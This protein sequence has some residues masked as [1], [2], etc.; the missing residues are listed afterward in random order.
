MRNGILSVVFVG[1]MC[2]TMMPATASGT[3]LYYDGARNNPADSKIYSFDTVTMSNQLVMDL[4]GVFVLDLAAS[5]EPDIIYGADFTANA[6]LAI[7]VRSKV[8]QIR[9]SFGSVQIYSLAYDRENRIL[10]GSSYTDLYIIDTATGAVTQHIGSFGLPTP[11]TMPGLTY[12]PTDGKLYGVGRGPVPNPL[13]LYDIDKNTGLAT[14]IGTN[15][16]DN[17]IADI[18]V[19]VNPSDGVMYGV[20][21]VGGAFGALYTI[22][23]ILG[24]ATFFPGGTLISPGVGY[25]LVGLAAPFVQT[26]VPAMTSPGMAIFGVLILAAAVIMVS[27]RKRNAA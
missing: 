15:L 27:R 8:A 22:D 14:Q 21:G 3:L 5:I 20:A 6:L 13:T 11:T 23:K 25:G 2:L 9:G 19:A 1:L 7:N 18:Y 4:P 17:L 26:S 16:T 24:V 10:Y 12:D